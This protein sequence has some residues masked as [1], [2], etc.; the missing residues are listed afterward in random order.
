MLKIG[1]IYLQE[2]KKIK[3][4][5]LKISGIGLVSANKILLANK[6]N[7]NLKCSELSQKNLI[8]IRQFINKNFIIETFLKRKIYLNIKN[9]ITSKSLR[10]KRHKLNLP[11]RGQRTRTNARTKRG[12]KKTISMKKK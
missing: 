9:L 1:G 7:P 5:L 4:A 8:K 12:K 10:G 6:I 11:V 2:N 3:F